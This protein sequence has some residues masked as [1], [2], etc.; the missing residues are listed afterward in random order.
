MGKQAQLAD[1][2]RLPICDLSWSQIPVSHRLK[3]A[4][5]IKHQAAIVEAIDIAAGWLDILGRVLAVVEKIQAAAGITAE[6]EA[7][8][9]ECEPWES[10]G[11]SWG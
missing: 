2:T 5:D 8:E 10:D 9:D 7:W 3:L 6:P 11:D 1:G 4:A